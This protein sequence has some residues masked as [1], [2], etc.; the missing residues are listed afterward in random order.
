MLG[1][2][3]CRRCN[4]RMSKAARR[5]FVDPAFTARACSDPLTGAC[6]VVTR[7]GGKLQISTRVVQTGAVLGTCVRKSSGIDPD[8]PGTSA[9]DD[10]PVPTMTIREC[11]AHVI[12]FTMSLMASR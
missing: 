3:S 6:N 7:E 4:A 11:S 5:A 8:E 1:Q 12:A 9:T 2:A 10:K